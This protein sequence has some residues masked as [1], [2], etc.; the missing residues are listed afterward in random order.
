MKPDFVT[1]NNTI[2]LV[3]DRPNGEFLL[4]ALLQQWGVACSLHE[5][6]DVEHAIDYLAGNGIYAD[7][8][9]HPFPSL[10]L[11][12]LHRPR[13]SGQEVLVWVRQRYSPSQ[14]PVV[15][16]SGANYYLEIAELLNL[17]AD[18][19][20][21]ASGPGPHKLRDALYHPIGVQ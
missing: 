18:Q 1:Q 15:V 3:E 20:V 6:N 16:L 13:T 17:G 9:R 19:A 7:R 11:L 8:L 4:E 2:L 10:V 5:V 12:D 14:L 21:H